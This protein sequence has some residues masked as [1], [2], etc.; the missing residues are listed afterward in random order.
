MSHSFP[1][2]NINI[3]NQHPVEYASEVNTRQMTPEEWAKYGPPGKHQPRPQFVSIMKKSDTER[4]KGRMRKGQC[5]DKQT[6]F[7]MFLRHGT[8]EQA[9]KKIAAETGWSRVDIACFRGAKALMREAEAIRAKNSG[10]VPTSAVHTCEPETVQSSGSIP[11]PTPEDQPAP[12]A[13]VQNESAPNTSSQRESI[14]IADTIAE[15]AASCLKNKDVIT[16]IIDITASDN[17]I[18]F[19]TVYLK[20]MRDRLLRL[21]DIEL[22]PVDREYLKDIITCVGCAAVAGLIAINDI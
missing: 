17:N 9:I 10:P 13:T 15:L 1:I 21:S 2:R 4:M 3:E 20:G 19:L 14:G 22:D 18:N 6:L 7:N 5:I 16:N 11:D 12:S 8:D